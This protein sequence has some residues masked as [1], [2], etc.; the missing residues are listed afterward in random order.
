[1]I[2]TVCLL[3][4]LGATALGGG[5]EMVVFASGNDFLPPRWLDDIPVIDSWLVP[6]LVLGAGFGVG[7][8]VT[9]YG[10][11]RRPHWRWARSAERSIGRHWS[12][13]AVILLGVGMLAWIGLELV[14]L[15]DRSW[16]EAVYGL[17]GALLVGLALSPQVQA[18]VRPEDR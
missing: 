7:A 14:L 18:Y 5:V 15:P 1:M 6:G 3:G 17:T 10:L 4:F 9:A 8:L 16:L 2:V 13:P 12:W 11:I